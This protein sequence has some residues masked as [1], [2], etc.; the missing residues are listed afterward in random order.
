MP[1]HANAI[2]ASSSMIIRS[3]APIRIDLAG[4]WT[5][6]PPFA[7]RE[8]GA[9]VNLAINR[10]TYASLRVRDESTIH[11]RS[12]DFEVD[13]TAPSSAAL[14]YDGQL[15]LVKAAIRRLNVSCGLDVVTR[16][17]AP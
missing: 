3:R 9:V 15:D 16:A 10:Y 2:R 14:V 7:P 4:G 17:D 11:L 6:V 12:E 8:G 5:D 13:V 1:G